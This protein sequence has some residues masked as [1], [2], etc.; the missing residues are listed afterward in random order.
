MPTWA[1]LLGPELVP[2]SGSPAT[3]T[4]EA[5]AATLD[6]AQPTVPQ[7]HGATPAW[8]SLFAADADGAQQSKSNGSAGGP[9]ADA[10]AA[11]QPLGNLAPPHRPAPP[12]GP[13]PSRWPVVRMDD[14][15]REVH[16]LQV[17]CMC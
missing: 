6:A 4:G 2:V 11:G 17:S 7:Q 13:P 9:G 1:A 3:G 10:A 14:G 16:W 8:D 12:A 15:G 5:H